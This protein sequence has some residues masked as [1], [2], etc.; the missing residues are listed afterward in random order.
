MINNPE[1]KLA[2]D[3]VH[4]TNRNIFLTGKAGTGKTTFLHSLKSTSYKRMV[5]VAPTGVAA[6]NA[7]G[8]TIHSFFQ[9]PFGPVITDRLPII[10]QISTDES[11]FK[12]KFSKT[13]IKIIK[14]LDLLVI[15]EISMVRADLLD[16]IDEVLRRYKNRNLPFGGVQLLLIGDLQQ[17]APVVKE[18]EWNMLR[19]Y[20]E[21]V[22]FFSS[23]ALQES[24]P[25]FIELKHIYRQK[26]EHFIKILNEIRDDCL[27]EN[28]IKELQKRYIPNF[29]PKN[30][31]GYITLTTHNINADSI[32][33]TQLKKIKAKEYHF[34][35]IIEGKFSEYSYPTK[36]DLRLK[37][38]VQVMYVKND[39]SFEKR[40]YNGKI[41]TIINIEDEKVF[42]KSPEDDEAIEV[43][44][45][46]WENIKYS[47]NEITKEIED[48]AVGSFIQHPLRLA[49]A[50]TIHKSQGLTFDKAVIDA[51]AAF[52]H[53]QTYVALSRCKTLE[54][55]ILSSQI[56]DNGII[57]DKTVMAFNHEVGKNQPKEKNL[58]ES[59]QAFQKSL[60]DELL[61]YKAFQYQINKLIKIVQDNNRSI[62]GDVLEKL[63]EIQKTGIELINVAD[64]F[65][66]QIQQLMLTEA[67]I[68][69]SPQLQERIKKAS[70]YYL[71][72]TQMQILVP[73]EKSTFSSDNKAVK[74]SVKEVL[75]KIHEIIFV[76]QT[77]LTESV[78]GFALKEFLLV[79]AKASLEEVRVKTKKKAETKIVSTEHPVLYERF[80]EWRKFH[81]EEDNVP[82][83]RIVNQK[84]IIGITNSLPGSAKQL[85]EIKGIGAMKIKKYGNEILT[86]VSDYCKEENLSLGEDKI[87]F[88]VKP[89]KKSKEISFELFKSGKTISEIAKERDYAETTIEGHL[90]Y[91][92][93]TDELDINQFVSKEK[94]NIIS[95]Y[96]KKRPEAFMNEVK[97]ALGDDITYGDI[98]FV[99]SYLQKQA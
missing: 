76:K 28:S 74:K 92:I 78:K 60:I 56:N 18:S 46:K 51:R 61:N 25:V 58:Q 6:I 5:V 90:A 63:Y 65:S 93:G 79:R 27:T 62:E 35:A 99:L 11:A 95:N 17:L 23:R 34:E 31:E 81:A 16:G 7:G 44:I 33:E 67:D 21:T 66:R 8:V 64:K 82:V 37:V 19:P 72:K 4:Y 48:E 9:M 85:N 41:G 15:D 88:P 14:S 13:K 54:G 87:E 1:I 32:N 59:K 71:D 77:C 69:S 91:F 73:L 47:L 52:A 55:L 68:E 49:W 94:I 57:C 98:R 70:T 2:H 83:Y 39:S 20:Y 96:Y 43:G 38:G 45:E 12:Q 97:L 89:K 86:M 36:Q 24:K 10:K 3:F 29:S 26:D 40:Y 80:R 30:D 53:G 75:V 84:A 22:F 42:V 50:I